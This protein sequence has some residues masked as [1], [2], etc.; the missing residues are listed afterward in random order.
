[1]IEKKNIKLFS[2]SFL[3]SHSFFL[4]MHKLHYTTVHHHM[5]VSYIIYQNKTVRE[6]LVNMHQNRDYQ[7]RFMQ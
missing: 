4:K 2:F 3:V 7:V 6:R 5:F 1:M